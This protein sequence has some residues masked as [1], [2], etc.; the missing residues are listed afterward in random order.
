MPNTQQS[1]FDHEAILEER[2]GASKK[3]RID[4]RLADAHITPLW[5]PEGEH[6]HV[7]WILELLLD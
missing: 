3:S 1:S 5:Y 4:Q 2:A 6:D 7:A